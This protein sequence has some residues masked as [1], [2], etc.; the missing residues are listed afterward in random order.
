M[1]GLESMIQSF[2]NE[3]N[4][5]QAFR[6]WLQSWLEWEMRN[7]HSKLF[8]IGTDIGKGIVPMEKEARLLRDVVGWCYQDVAKQATRVDVIWYGLNEQLK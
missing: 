8:L 4:P 3:P 5:R 1:F 2:L 6:S 7:G